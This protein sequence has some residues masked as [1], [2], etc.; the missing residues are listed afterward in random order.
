MNVT[1]QDTNKYVSVPNLFSSAAVG[2]T[3]LSELARGLERKGGWF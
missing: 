1:V 3:L 2:I